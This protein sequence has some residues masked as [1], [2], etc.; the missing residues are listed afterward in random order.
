MPHQKPLAATSVVLTLMLC[1]WSAAQTVPIDDS[2][3]AS[4]P[5]PSKTYQGREIAQTM[6]YLGAPWLIRESREREEQCATLLTALGVQVGE[7]VCDL[8]CGNGFYTLQLASLVGDQGTIL[9]VDIQQEMLGLLRARAESADIH[10]IRP[11]HSSVDDPHLP[12]QL[13]D[14][15][16]LVDV[17]HEFSHPAAMLQAIHRCLKPNGRVALV[18]FRQE[19][20][21][22]PIKRLHKMSIAQILKEFP[23]AGFKLV[24]QFERLPWQHVMFFA[25]SDSPLAEIKPTPWQADTS[26]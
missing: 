15:V 20:L 5:P 16:L 21:Q 9:A 2:A 26:R 11:I 23:P 7:T 24:G 19:D 4:I 10:N 25:R 8:G 13:V 6:H 12:T 3:T 22:V 18:E 17:Y 1:S 14:L